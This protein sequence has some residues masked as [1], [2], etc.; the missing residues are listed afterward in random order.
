MMMMIKKGLQIFTDKISNGK[1]SRRENNIISPTHYEIISYVI[2]IITFI[3][4]SNKIFKVK[5]KI[6]QN[7]NTHPRI[8]TRTPIRTHILNLYLNNFQCF[9]E[10]SNL[11]LIQ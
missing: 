4:G 8:C 1:F 9:F 10:N 5:L 6:I 11:N 7:M 3:R 2:I